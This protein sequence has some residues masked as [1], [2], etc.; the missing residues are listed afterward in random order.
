[1][2][3]SSCV[4]RSFLPFIFAFP[5][6]PVRVTQADAQTQNISQFAAWISGE[7]SFMLSF[8]GHSKDFIG[9]QLPASY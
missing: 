6:F 4:N 2:D 9:G 3:L 8:E 5:E 1:M 7:Y